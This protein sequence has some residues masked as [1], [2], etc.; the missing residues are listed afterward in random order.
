VPGFAEADGLLKQ[1]DG[2]LAKG[3][4]AAATAR[5]NE[6]RD[7]FGR[8][9]TAQQQAERQ[10]QA[11]TIRQNQQRAAQARAAEEAAAA[12]RAAAAVPTAAPANPPVA[13]NTPAAPTAAPANPQ[14]APIRQLMAQYERAMESK[15]I[16]QLRTVWPTIAA[17]DQ[18][19]IET[20][21]KA[22]K[23]WDVGLRVE[24]VEVS[25]PRALVRAA[26]QDTVNGTRTP[27]ASQIFRLAQAADGWKIESIG[28]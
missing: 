8:A 1:A 11:E 17:A 4:F 3:E 15:D 5:F 22:V 7:A 25:G 10:R 26:R 13:A 19:K 28:Q 21:F 2:L 16:T 6:A 18:K 9:R 20:A 14:E 12:A 27:A 23:T 24:A